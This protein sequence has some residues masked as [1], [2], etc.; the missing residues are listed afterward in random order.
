MKP[1]EIEKLITPERLDKIRRVVST[2][3]K[4][5]TLILE[6]VHDPH[7]LGAVLRTAESIGIHEIYALY[8]VE[9]AESLRKIAGH[10]SSS[11]AKKWIDIHIF[12][13]T[14]VCFEHVRRKYGKIYAAYLSNQAVSLYD[15]DLTASSALL[16]GNEHRGLSQEALELSDG[17]FVIPQFGFTQ[18]LNI[19]V[20]CAISLYEG[21]R[22]RME[23]GLYDKLFNESDSFHKELSLKYI[24]KSRPKIFRE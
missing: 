6:N 4:D 12:T 17:C 13:D 24:K 20:A 1:E 11:G 22:Q 19:S 16:F 5:F 3:Q 10:R 14:K 21:L 8:T 9:K 7:N 23:N 15:L 18:S 2:R